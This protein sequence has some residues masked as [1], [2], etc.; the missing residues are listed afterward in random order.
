MTKETAI[1]IVAGLEHKLQ[2]KPTRGHNTSYGYIKHYNDHGH[3]PPEKP[4]YTLDSDELEKVFSNLMESLEIRARI[5]MFLLSKGKTKFEE[6]FPG[7]RI[8]H[9]LVQLIHEI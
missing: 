1:L 5:R 7:F 2:E 8:N 4:D 3:L 6:L 9:S